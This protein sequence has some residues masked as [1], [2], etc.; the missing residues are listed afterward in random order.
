M[1]E[2]ESIDMD[3]A[4]RAV[5]RLATTK[6]KIFRTD[7]S[8]L[9]VGLMNKPGIRFHGEIARALLIWAEE[10][11]PAGEA[12]LNALKG[13]TTEGT[14]IPETLVELI[15]KENPDGAAS[16]IHK[17]WLKKPNLWQSSYKQFGEVIEKDVLGQVNAEDAALRRSSLMILGEVGTAESLPELRKLVTDE[18]ASIRV[19]AERAITQIGAR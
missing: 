2:L 1:R 8:R 9:L 18:E 3:R 10:P 6:P 12:A 11:G 14:P 17:L 4:E 7:I 19:L 16:E 13:Y 5:E 15:V